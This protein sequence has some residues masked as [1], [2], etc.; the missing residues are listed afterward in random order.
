MQ[1]PETVQEN[2]TQKILWNFEMQ[3]DHSIL[4]KKLD[5]VLINKKRIICNLVDFVVP[6]NYE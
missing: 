5:Q 1:K 4:T 3:T 6:V 2:E